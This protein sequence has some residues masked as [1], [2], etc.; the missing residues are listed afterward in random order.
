MD[1]ATARLV[2]QLYLHDIEEVDGRHKD[3]ETNGERSD[4]EVA[5]GLLK[6]DIRQLVSCE[7]DRRIA[8]RIALA[9]DLDEDAIDHVLEEEATAAEDQHLSCT[10]GDEQDTEPEN[11]R[12]TDRKGPD[13]NISGALAWLKKVCS[14]N[15]PAEEPK[16]P[17]L[18]STSAWPS[19]PSTDLFTDKMLEETCVGC[20]DDHQ[21]Y[22]ILQAPCGHFFCRWCF[23]RLAEA[24]SQDESLYPPSC[25]QQ[26]IPL[27]SSSSFLAT[28][29]IELLESKAEE[30]GTPNRTYCHDAS[31]SEF[32][33]SRY[34]RHDVATCP[35][36]SKGT[37]SMCKGP[38]HVD[39]DCPDD[40]AEKALET[41][42]IAQKWARCP[43]C[44]R[45]VELE[46]GCNHIRYR[47][48][49]SHPISNN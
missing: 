40:P 21:V 19:S 11:L 44:K 34:V 30:F 39:T 46:S 48:F 17:V 24:A 14:S 28:D 32:I 38:P 20:K 49:Q 22:D 35:K 42:A 12:A 25:C 7:I 10:S 36:C 13:G 33:P 4:A 43:N 5:F 31:C 37:C 45:R 26:T 27:S 15:K 9:G 23:H 16:V 41:L 6:H 8:E 2:R 3:K 29:L 18:A 47:A 1:E